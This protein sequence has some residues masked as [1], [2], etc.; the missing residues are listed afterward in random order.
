MI[1]ILI[2][3]TLILEDKMDNLHFQCTE[4]Q[5]IYNTY[6]HTIRFIIPLDDSLAC[7][8]LISLQDY[9]NEIIISKQNAVRNVYTGHLIDKLIQRKQYRFAVRDTF[10]IQEETKQYKYITYSGNMSKKI[11]EV[12]SCSISYKTRTKTASSSSTPIIN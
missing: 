10:P 2:Y 4:N 12:L 3:Y 8:I 1:T 5:H 7:T 9:K 6:I 11:A